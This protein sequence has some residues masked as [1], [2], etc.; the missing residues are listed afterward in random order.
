MRL[1]AASK[2]FEDAEL[3]LPKQ[4]WKAVGRS[5]SVPLGTATENGDRRIQSTHKTMMKINRIIGNLIYG[6][7]P[8]RPMDEF[9]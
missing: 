3:H 2:R 7:Y 9:D 6:N 5:R 8:D 4:W 1:I